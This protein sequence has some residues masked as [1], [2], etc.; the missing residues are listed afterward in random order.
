M[1]LSNMTIRD[2]KDTISPSTEIFVVGIS[3]GI[4][5]YKKS[6]SFIYRVEMDLPVY[7]IEVRDEYDGLKCE[8]Y[9]YVM[10]D[11]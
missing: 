5:M 2:I 8:P 3:G 6:S 4:Y 11:D 10:I 1:R 9:L 7:L